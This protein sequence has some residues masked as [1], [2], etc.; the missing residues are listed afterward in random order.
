[1][2][3]SAANYGALDWEVVSATEQLRTIVLHSKP[4]KK[5]FLSGGSHRRLGICR[6]S[7]PEM[8]NFKKRKPGELT[9]PLEIPR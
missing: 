5:R 1:M 6:P 2:V 8:R 7:G 4:A 3:A 9:L